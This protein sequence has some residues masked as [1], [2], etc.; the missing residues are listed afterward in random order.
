[1]SRLPAACAWLLTATMLFGQ[2]AAS[3]QPAESGSAP[4]AA[5]TTAPSNAFQCGDNWLAWPKATGDWGGLRSE[6]AERG[7][8]IDIDV[9]NIVQQNT[10]GGY[11]TND[12]FKYSGSGDITLRLDTGKLGLWPGGMLL[13]NGEPKWGDGANPYV[14]SL[15]PV[16]LDAVKPGAGEGAMMTLSEWIFFQSLFE[17]KLVLIAGKLDGSRAFDRNVFANDER[18]QFMNAGLRNNM[19]IP[20]FLPYTNLGAGFVLNPTDWLSVVTAVA[21]SEG[22]AKTTGFETTFHGPTH[23]TVIHEWDVKVK[24]FGLDGNYRAGFVWSSKESNHLQPVS[25]F[26]ETGPLMMRLLGPRLMKKVGALLPVNDSPDNVALYANFDQYLYQEECDP[27]QGVGLFGRFGWARDD[28]NAIEYFYS[29]GIGGRGIINGRDN[30]TFGLGYYHINLS[31]DLPS[32][33]H[34][35]QGVELYY[36]IEV[37]PWLHITPDIQVI[38]N[39]GG[40]DSA[41]CSLVYGI[42]MQMNL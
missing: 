2:D 28:V 27:K 12:A 3:S 26:R 21:D 42:R 38:A 1:M 30:D 19:I 22:R 16:N 6:L 14:G 39:P 10:H 9:T 20:A 34:S 36:N 31:D 41:D 35:E 25:P 23:T 8:T 33:L 40:T 4:P 18:T 11:S 24:P 37:A 13:L 15:L 7:I 29:G 5:R 17:N 32:F